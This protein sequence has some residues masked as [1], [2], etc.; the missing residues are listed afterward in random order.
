M[1][2]L[3]LFFLLLVFSISLGA[4]KTKKEQP[5]ILFWLFGILLIAIAGFRDESRFL[6]YDEYVDTIING[7]DR[8][9]LSFQLIVS[10]V[11][12]LQLPYKIVFLFYAFWGVFLKMKAISKWSSPIWLSLVVY[13][14]HLFIAEECAAMRVGVATGFLLLALFELCNK[15]YLYWLL[16]TIFAIFFHYSAAFGLLYPLI[17]RIP[18]KLK[19]C[20]PLLIIAYLMPWLNISLDTFFS[21]FDNQLLS[22]YSHYL[23]TDEIV[24][25]YNFSQILYCF[26]ALYVIK[27]IEEIKAYNQYVGELVLVYLFSLLVLPV[28]NVVPVFAFRIAHIFACVEIILIPILIKFLWYKKGYR[29]FAYLLVAYLFY[30]CFITAMGAMTH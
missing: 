16:Y 2:Y 27:N 15:R 3:L 11:K 9:E 14:A 26:I 28:F 19:Y 30:W 13:I 7:N 20:L 21:Y 24:S 22:Y 8:M 25:V 29:I 12:S 1:S 23:Q 6:D 5:K 18:V 10:S 4:L 17:I